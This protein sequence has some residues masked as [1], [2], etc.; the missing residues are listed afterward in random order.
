MA[1]YIPRMRNPS[2]VQRTAYNNLDERIVKEAILKHCIDVGELAS[3]IQHL[4]PDP[5]HQHIKRADD[6]QIEKSMR[7]F[8]N[9]GI[10]T[11]AGRFAQMHTTMSG[12]ACKNKYT[13]RPHRPEFEDSDPAVY[14][15]A[16]HHTAMPSTARS[17][18]SY[19]AS[20]IRQTSDSSKRSATITM[21][22]VSDRYDP[23]SSESA[24][25]QGD[26][27]NEILEG[28][29]KK[30]G[31]EAIMKR[32]KD[33]NERQATRKESKSFTNLRQAT[34]KP[35]INTE[36]YA[37]RVRRNS[38]GIFQ[39]PTQRAPQKRLENTMYEVRRKSDDTCREVPSETS[40]SREEVEIKNP[41]ASPNLALFDPP[42]ASEQRY[43]LQENDRVSIARYP[44]DIDCED[45]ISPEQEYLEEEMEPQSPEDGEVLREEAV[46][47]RY[48]VEETERRREE[49]MEVSHEPAQK[50]MKGSHRVTRE[51][52]PPASPGGEEPIL[53]EDN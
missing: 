52:T 13:N 42:A 20:V 12:G 29:M 46:E 51:L 11:R 17:P 30:H 2:S 32:T 26:K 19:A 39:P 3:Y 50:K 49:D 44:T 35:R 7:L 14:P 21:S 45:E 43:C 8:Y 28:L 41:T 5:N 1:P 27:I 6:N 48:G 24:T 9:I 47:E 25:D 34:V 23:K 31:Q 38:E 36:T 33:I 22:R 10:E 15:T 4:P 18:T 37:R 40:Q 53:I 16:A